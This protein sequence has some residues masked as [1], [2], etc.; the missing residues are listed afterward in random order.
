M[1]TR[2]FQRQILPRLAPRC[3]GPVGARCFAG[4]IN[5][6]MID[7]D[8][9]PPSSQTPLYVN[10]FMQKT[11]AEFAEDA[12][13]AVPHPVVHDPGQLIQSD[14]GDPHNTYG[15]AEYNHFHY[16][17]TRE[18]TFPRKPDLSK[19]EL[20]AGAQVVRTDVW[21]DPKEPAI[22]SIAKFS[23]ENFRPVGYFENA[24]VPDSC[25]P[26]GHLDFRT[27]RLPLNHADRR[28]FFYFMS[29][30]LGFISISIVRSIVCKAVHS[31]WPSKDVF[32][33]GVVEVD[34]RP[35]EM[36]QNFVVK[37]RGKPVF[38]RRRTPDMIAKAKKDDVLLTSM[39]DPEID[40]VRAQR[41]E[42]LIMI[43]VCTHLGCIPF[44]DQGN[45]GGWFC[46]CHG[47]HYDHSGRIRQGPAPKNM[48][49]PP[50]AFMDDFTVKLG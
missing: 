35:I 12:K 42:W 44:V 24:P 22:T 9:N 5:H 28:P 3:L 14:A 49:V 33:A 32:A 10:E 21:V 17:I 47:S 16:D 37:W 25:V 4:P 23:P 8:F 29:A 13:N 43:G 50:H 31:L 20:A 26:A 46:P 1:L 48:E 30:S 2:S 11:P 7:S 40:S 27:N 6:P 45:W 38:V 15:M 34:L 19:G 36:G 41:P 39:R 18:P